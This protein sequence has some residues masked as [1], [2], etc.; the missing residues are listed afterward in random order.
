MN[1]TKDTLRREMRHRR[2]GL[3]AASVASAG[4]VIARRLAEFLLYRR[5][6]VILAYVG[7]DNEVPT[8]DLIG[9]ALA[10]GK[11]VYL[12]RIDLLGFARFDLT[13]PLTASSTGTL[14]PVGGDLY[15]PDG[16]PAILLAPLLAWSAS[17]ARLGRG[18][19]WYD[20]VLPT[21][22]MPAVGVA[23]D[24]QERAD[25]PMEPLDVPLDY[26]VTEN[27][28]IECGRVLSDGRLS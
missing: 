3:D 12:P 17:G 28:L 8:E 11:Q 2:A 19:G 10:R 1:S 18:G 13:T 9:D 24:W 27:R 22:A 7:R 23:Y 5:A 21:L 16:R 4:A 20:R 26:V 15:V 14:E 6:L 25:V